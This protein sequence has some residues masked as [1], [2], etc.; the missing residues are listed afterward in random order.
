[1]SLQRV[2]VAVLGPLGTY[3]HEAAYRIFGDKVYYEEQKTIS[4]IFRAIH[5]SVYVGIVPQENT[6]FGTVIETY[7]KLRQAKCGFVKGEVAI[8]IQHCL[9]VQ[10]GVQLHEIEYVL[11]HEQALGQCQDFLTAHL[12]EATRVK[13]TSTAFAAHSLLSSPR[14]HAAI[15]SKVCST[16][17]RGLEVLRESIQKQTDNFTRF[18]IVVRD[19]SVQL[20]TT[21]PSTRGKALIRL[22]ISSSSPAEKPRQ[23]VVQ[24][25][26]PL[27]LSVVRI[28][29]RPSD[30]GLPFRSVYFVELTSAMDNI[31]TEQFQPPKSWSQLVEDA[32]ATIRTSGGE[33]DLI[34]LW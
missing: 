21:L 34:G 15:C 33:A 3:T 26:T 13:V 14:N 24:Y 31:E 8:P 11:S 4:D 10:E 23:D 30:D 18:Y 19:Q 28:D 29:R 16:L 17:F 22:W 32:L 27:G 9:V 2:G 20:P 7:D 5:D 12:P 6:V 1:M 25:L